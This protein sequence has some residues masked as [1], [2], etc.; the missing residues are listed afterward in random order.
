LNEPQQTDDGLVY[1]VVGSGPAVLLVHEGIAD[2]TMW[3]PQWECWSDRFTLIRY[4][5]RGFGESADPEGEFSLH[6]DALAVLDGAGVG[7]AH[8]VGASMG[9]KAALDLT[10]A[11]PD[12]VAAL[13]AVVAT[14]SGWEHSPDLTARFDEVEAAYERGGLEAANEVELQIWLDGEQRKPE[15]VDPALR[16][17]VAGMNYAA[18]ERQEAREQRDAEVEPIELD[19]PAVGRLAEVT[20]PVLVVNGALDQPSVNAGAAAIAAG[21]P[22]ARAVE[23]ADTA[24]LPS[25]ERPDAFDVAVL[26]FLDGLE[27]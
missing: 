3:D 11:A 16:S 22:G 7:R 9:G 20:V 24:H 19:P 27:A 18:L 8:L 26:P 15:Q 13:V 23:I 5:Q 21:I 12:R 10:L 2:R 1:E 14:P 25:L 17:K 4:D 6:S